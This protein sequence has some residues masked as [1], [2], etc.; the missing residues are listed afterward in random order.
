MMQMH[1]MHAQ[2]GVWLH[3]NRAGEMPYLNLCCTQNMHKREHGYV[4]VECI[5]T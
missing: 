3:G 2:N 4:E 5:R 1:T